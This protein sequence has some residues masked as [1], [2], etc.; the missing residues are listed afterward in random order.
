MYAFRRETTPPNS[1]HA[2]R[3]STRADV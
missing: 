1:L 2:A 3:V